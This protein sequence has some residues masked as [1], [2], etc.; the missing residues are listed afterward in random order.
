MATGLLSSCLLEVVFFDRTT[1]YSVLVERSPQTI[2]NEKY[3]AQLCKF[4][5]FSHL[6]VKEVGT[7]MTEGLV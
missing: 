3:A 2:R 1:F 6:K 4:F 5:T 7:I